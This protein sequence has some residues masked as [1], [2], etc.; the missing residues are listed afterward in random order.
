MIFI[1][2]FVRILYTVTL[3]L[4]GLAFVTFLM[5]DYTASQNGH[6]TFHFFSFANIVVLALFGLLLA[7]RI[8]AEKRPVWLWLG[9]PSMIV[10][11]GSLLYFFGFIT[12]PIITQ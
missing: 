6:G 12:Y 5:V 10:V 7:S 8:L 3:L 2:G 4:V 11:C 9:V 1:K